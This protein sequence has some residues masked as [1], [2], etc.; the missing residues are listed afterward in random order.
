M[1]DLTLWENIEGE[2]EFFDPLEDDGPIHVA[3]E[4]PATW[5]DVADLLN[6]IGFDVDW[7]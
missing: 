4:L 6:E 2:L 1:T 3:T 5:E 7:Q